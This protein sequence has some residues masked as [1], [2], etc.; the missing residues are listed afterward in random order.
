MHISPP[1]VKLIRFISQT[2]TNC[3]ANFFSL[4]PHGYKNLG[5][6]NV[7]FLHGIYLVFQFCMAVMQ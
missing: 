3:I 4:C 2:A 5:N 1:Y 6:S 7:L